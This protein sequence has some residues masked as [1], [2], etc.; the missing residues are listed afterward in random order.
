MSLGLRIRSKV[1]WVQNN[2]KIHKHSSDQVGKVSSDIA[3]AKTVKLA[4]ILLQQKMVQL[5]ATVKT[6]KLEQ[7]AAAK[8]GQ[9]SSN[10]KKR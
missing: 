5:A 9:V 7:F 8:N 4:A 6:V 3:A 10:S 1:N 2:T